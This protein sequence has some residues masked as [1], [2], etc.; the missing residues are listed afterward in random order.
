MNKIISMGLL[1]MFMLLFCSMNIQSQSTNIIEKRYPVTRRSASL[2]TPALS[3]PL[4]TTVNKAKEKTTIYG[5]SIYGD[6]WTTSNSPFGI[7]SFEAG[8]TL[9][10][11]KI[12]D[13]TPITSAAGDYIDGNYCYMDFSTNGNSLISVNYNIVDTQ[14]WEITTISKDNGLCASTDMTYDATTKK[15]YAC[16][17]HA[18]E[19]G[20]LTEINPDNGDA[21]Y[22]AEIPFMLAMA[23]NGNGELYGIYIDDNNMGQLYRINKQTGETKL[24]GSTGISVA[25]YYQSATFN[26]TDGQLYWVATDIQERSALYKINTQTGQAT[27]MAAF[28]NNEEFVGIFIKPPF[29][30]ENAPSA[31][32][33]LKAVSNGNGTFTGTISFQ[34][35]TTTVSGNTLNSLTAI[36][37]YRGDNTSPIHTINNPTPGKNYSWQETGA[38]QGNNAYKVIARNEAGEGITAYISMF[39]GYDLPEMITEFSVTLNPNEQ[40]ALT[41]IAPEKG[42]NGTDLDTSTL[43]YTIE[44]NIDGKSEMIAKDI[45]G[46]VYT[47]EDIKIDNQT[48]VYYQIIPYSPGGGGKKSIAKGV[49]VGTPYPLP[50]KESFTDSKL[51]YSPWL[52]LTLSGDAGWSINFL[53]NFPGTMAYDDDAGMAIFNSFRSAD[54]AEARLTSPAIS[55]TGAENPVLSFYFF[56]FILENTPINDRMQVEISVNGG[57]FKNI[58][59][60]LFIQSAKDTRWTLCEIPL[61]DYKNS[62]RINIGFKGISNNGA[63]MCLDLITI[64]DK[65]V[66]GISSVN[67][68]DDCKI[69]T[70][71]NH[72]IIENPIKQIVSVYTIDGKSCFTDNNESITSPFLKEGVYI[73]KVGEKVRKVFITK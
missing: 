40:P 32:N 19:N 66:S 6:D 45:Q 72:L 50:F 3:T 59:D 24:I 4:Q 20:V 14:T 42:I 34:A 57:E 68:N 54:G 60:A 39:A 16:A 33:N 65:P 36:D 11:Q 71:N 73:I 48:Y 21:K 38:Q 56:Y 15:I 30:D 67:R 31:V 29:V 17:S 49:V 69:I 2:S 41:W 35:P 53:S 27:Y 58:P 28:P 55:L 12:M 44:R 9:D 1:T 25:Y 18:G 13:I 46:T 52:S 26:R 8:F 23:V 64:E 10:P 47:D 63:D 22:I 51:D 62:K 43:T 7:Y 37:I 5:I 61:T 70:T